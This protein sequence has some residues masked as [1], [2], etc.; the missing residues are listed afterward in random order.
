M[1]ALLKA[2]GEDLKKQILIGSEMENQTLPSNVLSHRKY[3]SFDITA[4]TIGQASH[5]KQQNS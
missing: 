5:R 3:Q 2:A 1:D 4:M